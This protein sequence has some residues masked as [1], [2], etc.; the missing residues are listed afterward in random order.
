MNSEQLFT[1]ALG[2]NAPWEVRKIG[3]ETTADQSKELH[4]EIGFQKGAKFSDETGNLCGVHDTI[5]KRWRHLNFFEHTCYIHCDVPRLYKQ[6]GTVK[7]VQVP[8]SRPGSGFTLLFEAFMMYLIERE[9]P[10]K[11]VAELLKIYPQ[12]V[13]NVF[14]YWVSLAREKDDPSAIT[15]LG[16]DETSSR[17]GHNYVTIGVDM[18]AKRVIHAVEGK[19]KGAVAQIQ[20]RLVEKGVDPEQITQAS[21]DLS[22]AYIA[23]V[24]ERFPK[25]QITFDRFHVVKMLNEAM[26]KLRKLEQKEHALLKGMK[27]SFLKNP[28]N[29]TPK[30]QVKL[31][32][33]IALYP[34]L[35]N[36]YR[37][38]IL[39]NDLWG[40]PD[41]QTAHQFM[42]EWCAAV[43]HYKIGPFIEFTKTLIGHWYGI[44]NFIES[45]LTNGLLEGINHKIQLAKRR[46]RGFRNTNSYINMIYFLCAKLDFDYPHK[47]I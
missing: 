26:D 34:S 21:M 29:L 9:M 7:L 36:A 15:K 43:Q 11:R 38:K 35:G 16:L 13:W 8:W 41:K 17:K 37:L 31:D 14:D 40:M 47:I 1:L 45:R 6:D 28:E 2:L 24:T 23:G 32:E 4:I 39:F 12:R 46:A 5:A 27:Y 10:V 33:T 25:A 20:Q 30:Q 22:P 19:G 42:I 3:F 44:L 18:T